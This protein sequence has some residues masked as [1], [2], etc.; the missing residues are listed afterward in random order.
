[1]KI[2]EYRETEG[3][4]RAQVAG[5]LGVS[6]TAVRKWEVGLARPSADRL[7]A[8]AGLLGCTIDELFGRGGPAG[9]ESGTTRGA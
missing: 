5:R 9:G 1:M 4:T 3:L 2:R 6:P 7:P 8:L